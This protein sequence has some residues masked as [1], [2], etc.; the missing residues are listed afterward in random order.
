MALTA[1]PVMNRDNAAAYGTDIFFLLLLHK[2]LQPIPAYKLTV[3]HQTYL[4][5]LLI[6]LFKILD[7]PAGMLRTFITIYQP[8]VPGT[9]LNPA[10]TAVFRFPF[11]TVLAATAR[12][13]MITMLITDQTIHPAGGKQHRVNLPFRHL[14]KPAPL[15]FSS[16]SKTP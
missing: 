7:Q 12:L 11:I 1:F 9:V 14:H 8:L 5:P 15:P 13:F 3:L 16:F 2:P 6:T 4:I 10:L